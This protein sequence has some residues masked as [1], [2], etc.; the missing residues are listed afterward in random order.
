MLSFDISTNHVFKVRVTDASNALVVDQSGNVGI[1]TADPSYNLDVHNPDF[2][3]I[4]RLRNSKP[5]AASDI[6]M[7]MGTTVLG[8][9][10]DSA[11]TTQW[12]GGTNLYLQAGGSTVAT[13]TPLANT[14]YPGAF[15]LTSEKLS[16]GNVEGTTGQVLRAK[17]DGFGGVEWGLPGAD[18]SGNGAM[19]Y[20]P[21]NLNIGLNSTNSGTTDAHYNQFVAPTTAQYTEMTIFCGFNTANIYNGYVYVGIY[22]NI[23]GAAPPST[24]GS[25]G[26]PGTR[27]AQGF[28][29][30]FVLATADL[31]TTP[32]NTYLHFDLS[33]GVD[34]SANT[35]Y[36]AAVGNVSTLGPPDQFHLIEHVDYTP[37]TGIVLHE[38]N[39]INTT[40]GLPLAANARNDNPSGVPHLPFWFRIYN[41]NNPFLSAPEPTYFLHQWSFGANIPESQVI[42]VGQW[43]WLYPGFGGNYNAHS[44]DASGASLIQAGPGIHPPVMSSGF[45]SAETTGPFGGGSLSYTINNHGLN[46][47]LGKDASGMSQ[48]FRI[49]VFAYCNVDAS[50]IPTNYLTFAR[51]ATALPA[52]DCAAIPWAGSS[53]T[54]TNSG[55]VRNGISV[56]ISAYQGNSITHTSSGSGRNISV[57][58][59]VRVAM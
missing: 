2:G 54:W 57:S 16:I 56:A 3:E 9:T 33:G 4:L 42:E 27:L 59:P 23:P 51:T 48:G 37:Q 6:E 43:Y 29:Q 45:T 5:T 50:G 58:I 49:R 25:P 47:G 1:G 18:G 36:W 52:V 30:N 46:S 15:D 55:I 26:I 38:N 7:L 34:L 8:S 40:I 35:L 17:G 13:A 12:T 53:L 24:V 10:I 19:P 41:T 22:S 39:I 31:S 11:V 20:E 32:K 21:W 44:I 14:T 28:R